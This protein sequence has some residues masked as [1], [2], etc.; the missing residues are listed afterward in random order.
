MKRFLCALG[1]H[2]WAEGVIG[3]DWWRQCGRCGVYEV[4]EQVGEVRTPW[5]KV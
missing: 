3:L 2:Q 1:L 5:R 4:A